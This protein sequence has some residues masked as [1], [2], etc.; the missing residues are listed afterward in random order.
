MSELLEKIRSRGY[1]KVIIRPTDLVENRIEN[2]ADLYRILDNS[3]ARIRHRWFGFP[4]I[5]WES[6]TGRGKDWIGQEFQW[7]R[8]L[9]LW[10]FYQSGQFVAYRGL[11]GDWADHAPAL[12]VPG[13]GRPPR[14]PG[15]GRRAATAYRGF[16]VGGQLDFHGGGG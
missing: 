16:S 4:H 3:A 6:E 1:W 5:Q 12:P 14:L 15:Y 10:R 9:E 8:Y 2:P 13:R 7:G 11:Y